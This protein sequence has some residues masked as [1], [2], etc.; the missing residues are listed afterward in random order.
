MTHLQ[1]NSRQSI[2][3]RVRIPINSDTLSKPIRTVFRC[4]RTVV[5]AKRRSALSLKGVSELSQAFLVAYGVLSRP[6]ATSLEARL[7][8]R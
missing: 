4:I 6:K 2:Y 7:G 3:P 5:G 1:L 8:S